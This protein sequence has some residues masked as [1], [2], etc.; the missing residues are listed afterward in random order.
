[1]H[2]LKKWTAKEEIEKLIDAHYYNQHSSFSGFSKGFQEK[3]KQSLLLL[4]G[5]LL[6]DVMKNYWQ[7]FE[8]CKNVVSAM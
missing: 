6:L 3:V 1:M 7:L 5:A 2:A 4:R 8:L